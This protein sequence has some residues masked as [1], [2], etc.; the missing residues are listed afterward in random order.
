MSSPSPNISSM[1]TGGSAG[2]WAYDLL[3]PSEPILAG[4]G[5]MIWTVVDGFGLDG[6]ADR[7][8]PSGMVRV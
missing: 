8:G 2:G 6:A 3:V 4:V 5:G 7:I 1:T